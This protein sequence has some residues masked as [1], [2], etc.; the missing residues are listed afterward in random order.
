MPGPFVQPLIRRLEVV[1]SGDGGGRSSTLAVGE[2]NGELDL[3][4]HVIGELSTPDIVVSGVTTE[5]GSNF[6]VVT[7]VLTDV[8]AV[9]FVRS[10]GDGDIS[11]EGNVL[12]DV[13][14]GDGVGAVDG[15]VA[16]DGRGS[17]NE[18]VRATDQGRSR[19][20]L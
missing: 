20:G 10:D 12:E 7:D 3:L 13:A 6:E 5:G 19:E 14:E 11:T 18:E 9:S 15:A 8:E 17:F 1:A 2:A 16:T 4:A